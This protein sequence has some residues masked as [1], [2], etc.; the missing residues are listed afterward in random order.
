MEFGIS[1]E[2]EFWSGSRRGIKLESNLL[3]GKSD[4]FPVAVTISISFT[5]ILPYLFFSFPGFTER[6]TVDPW[7]A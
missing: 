3:P 6:G 4:L 1:K 5:S 2:F 7:I